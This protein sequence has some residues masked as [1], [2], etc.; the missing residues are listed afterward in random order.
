M[1]DIHV[2]DFQVELPARARIVS[3]LTQGAII[4]ADH[5]TS[6]TVSLSDDGNQYTQVNSA[7]SGNQVSSCICC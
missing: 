5:L 4:Y 3:V 1:I 6:Y 7:D 2:F